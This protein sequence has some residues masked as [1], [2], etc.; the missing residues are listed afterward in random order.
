M[1]PREF[2]LFDFPEKEIYVMLTHEYRTNLFQLATNKL[3]SKRKLAKYLNFNEN[4]LYHIIHARIPSNRC[5]RSAIPLWFLKRVAKLTQTN[6]K[7]IEKNVVYI[8]GLGRSKPTYNL[9][10]PLLET[11]ELAS[12]IGNLLGD[13]HEGKRRNQANYFNK[14]KS[15]VDLFHKNLIKVFGTVGVRYTKNK[16]AIAFPRYLATI[17]THLYKISFNTFASRIPKIFFSSPRLAT[18]L[19]RS[20]GDDEAWVDDRRIEFYSANLHLLKDIK[21]LIKMHYPKMVINNIRTKKVKKQGRIDYSYGLCILSKGLKP[22]ARRIGFN[23]PKKIEKL[24]FA[25]KLQELKNKRRKVSYTKSRILELLETP[26]TQED[27]SRKLII[28]S[29]TN[30]KHLRELS[31]KESIDIVGKTQT[32]SILWVRKW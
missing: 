14:E 23:H 30:G 3:G 29:S 10:L 13:G 20:F 32:G 4:H 31:K 27:I 21:K 16:E 17:L 6:V 11:T 2:H 5:N 9:K 18:A 7:E 19:I 1:K 8:R 28:S 26:M 22:F 25:I 15:L 12:I 24:N